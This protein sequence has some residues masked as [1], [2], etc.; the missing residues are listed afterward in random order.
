LT[1]QEL[2]FLSHWQREQPEGSFLVIQLLEI[3]N[4]FDFG[5]SESSNYRRS[6]PELA[7][8]AA[9]LAATAIGNAVARMQC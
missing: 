1:F 3:H 7:N 9:T 4:L 8:S 5:L 2:F 6:I